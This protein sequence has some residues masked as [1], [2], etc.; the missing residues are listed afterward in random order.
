[1][2]VKKLFRILLL[3]LVVFVFLNADGAENSA[4]AQASVNEIADEEI[5]IELDEDLIYDGKY[6]KPSYL[7]SSKAYW[8]LSAYSLSNDIALDEYILINACDVFTEFYKNEFEWKQVRDALRKSILKSRRKFPI[9]FRLYVPLM[10]E[11]YDFSLMAFPIH[12]DSVMR[13]VSQLGL[14]SVSMYSN[15]NPLQM[16]CGVEFPYNYFPAT[17]D[18]ILKD[19]FTL[20]FIPMP[21]DKAENIIDNVLKNGIDAA[22]LRKVYAAFDIHLKKFDVLQKFSNNTHLSKFIGELDRISI[23]ESKSAPVP[24]FTRRYITRTWGTEVLEEAN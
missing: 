15:K 20:D 2:F 19:P 5:D 13:N 4:F 23:Y 14:V 22:G 24:F 12:A 11:R 3:V 6:K 7:N 10:I 8:A 18:V 1:M 16:K 9:H 21:R 17:S